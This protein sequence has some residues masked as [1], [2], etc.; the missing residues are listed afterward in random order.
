MRPPARIEPWL[1]TVD[2]QTWV[3]E[4]PDK[5]SYQRRLA[6]WLTHVGQLAAHQVAEF[7]CASKQAVWLWIAQYN[8][9][10]PEG[11]QR[12]GRGGRRWAYLS[13]KE[14]ETFLRHWLPRAAE[15]QVLT[16]QQLRS[17]LEKRLERRVS[18]G[19]VYGLLHRCGWRKLGPRPRHPQ[20]SPGAQARFKKNSPKPSKRS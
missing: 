5:A 14:E 11:L 4:A 12:Q 18:L 16:A 9:Q 8:Q 1:D 13:A 3:R 7:L 19:Y 2:L 6:I 20:A 17:Q 15:G 10:G